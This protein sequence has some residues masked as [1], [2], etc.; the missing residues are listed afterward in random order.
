VANHGA[1]ICLFNIMALRPGMA[2][3]EV[4]GFVVCRLRRHAA[5]IVCFTGA[6]DRCRNIVGGGGRPAF[7][8]VT[9]G[10]VE[11]S[12]IKAAL[13]NH[14]SDATRSVAG[15]CIWS[16]YEAFGVCEDSSNA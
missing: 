11:A 15:K 16:A 7:A 6:P 2:F 9:A 5:F 10:L 13:A 3:A 14:A 12:R 8:K 4:A 1:G